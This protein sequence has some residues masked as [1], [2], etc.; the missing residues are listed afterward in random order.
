MKRPKKIGA[1]KSLS[2]VLIPAKSEI[3]AP[4]YDRLYQLIA[5]H[6]EDLDRTNVRI[7]LAWCTSWKPDADGRLT[8]GKCKKATDLDRELAPYDFVILLNRDFWQN[9]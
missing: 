4:M 3:G 5:D 9:V 8:L 1:P 6:H 2:Y 7:A